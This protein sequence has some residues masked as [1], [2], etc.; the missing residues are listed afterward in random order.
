MNF[1]SKLFGIFIILLVIPFLV[2]AFLMYSAAKDCKDSIVNNL[3]TAI[4]GNVDN[5]ANDEYCNPDNG[6]FMYA[7]KLA[8][9]TG[10]FYKYYILPALI[11]ALLISIFS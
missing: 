10:K 8:D 11:L 3:P 4:A 5:N 7:Q 9:T 1:L 2:I 6:K